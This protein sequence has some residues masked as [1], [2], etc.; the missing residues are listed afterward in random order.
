[1]V[2]VNKLQLTWVG[3]TDSQVIVTLN[4]TV[5]INSTSTY[6][7][8]GNSYWPTTNFMFGN[9]ARYFEG[10]L[11]QIINNSYG[12]KFNVNF[13]ESDGLDVFDNSG[14]NNK[15]AI[16]KI[17]TVFNV[18]QN[19]VNIKEPLPLINGCF[20]NKN[21][22]TSNNLVRPYIPN[23][24]DLAK[25]TYLFT[26]ATEYSINASG[27]GDYPTI[28]AAIL[29]QNGSTYIK[30]NVQAGTYYENDIIGVNNVWVNAV[31]EVIVISNGLS[32]TVSPSNY[33]F[34]AYAN[35]QYNLIPQEYKHNLY[36]GSNI[37]FTNFTFQA[38][39]V[40]YNCHQDTIGVWSSIFHNCKFY[41]IENNSL[42]YLSNIGLGG[43]IRQEMFYV[44]CEFDV[45]SSLSL[46]SDFYHVFWH[47]ETNSIYASWLHLINCTANQNNLLVISQLNNSN[48]IKDIIH[49]E[50]C[51]VPSGKGISYTS[52]SSAFA[53]TINLNII[54]TVLTYSQTNRPNYL[55]YIQTHLMGGVIK[56]LSSEYVIPTDA[57][58]NAVITAGQK[59]YAEL[60]ALVQTDELRIT[61]TSNNISRLIVRKK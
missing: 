35:T 12:Y 56:G 26:G 52:S 44:N 37:L 9:N 8:T 59:T 28:R 53:Y 32:T 15:L 60:D 51:I 19:K 27:T 17:A 22:L 41:K 20:I 46:P 40:K 50:N 2:R 45:S 29:A 10:K 18:W 55:D 39:D 57:E 5:I 47:N 21:S 43:D 54:N 36:I 48:D 4:D 3:N 33:S 11:Y 49:I 30:I 6:G 25:F 31:G 16:V 38:N 24:F 7:W 13:N 23:S 42:T 14:Y 34:V 58:I 1:M 61:K